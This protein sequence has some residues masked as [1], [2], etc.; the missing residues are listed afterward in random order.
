MVTVISQCAVA[1]SAQKSISVKVLAELKATTD[2]PGFAPAPNLNAMR[3]GAVR[4]TR[5]I[6]RR[7]Q[8]LYVRPTPSQWDGRLNISQPRSA[9]IAATQVEAEKRGWLADEAGSPKVIS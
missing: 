1:E 3:F 6:V 9:G 2:M 7:P 8:S 5:L 4:K